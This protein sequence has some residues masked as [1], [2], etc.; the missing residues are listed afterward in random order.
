MQFI[1]SLNIELKFSYTASEEL[2]QFLVLE[3]WWYQLVYYQFKHCAE[4]TICIL[5]PVL[6]NWWYQF[7]TS[8]STLVK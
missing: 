6:E 1:T 5:T 3:N 2:D 7:I 4:V 8:L